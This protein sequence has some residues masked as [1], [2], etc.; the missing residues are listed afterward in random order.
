MSVKPLLLP[1]EPECHTFKALV[2]FIFK[3]LSLLSV[4]VCDEV[5]SEIPV[6]SPPITFEPVN[7]TAPPILSLPLQ[8]AVTNVPNA[9]VGH[10]VDPE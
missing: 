10:S 8:E 2:T 5:M 3:S 1:V 4:N 6:Y 7:Q 9:L